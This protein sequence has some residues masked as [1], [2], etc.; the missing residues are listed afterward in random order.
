MNAKL[1]LTIQKTEEKEFELELPYYAKSKSGNYYWKVY[2]ENPTDCIQLDVPSELNNFCGVTKTFTSIIFNNNVE[3][4][5]CS[6]LEF[7]MAY[8]K[9]MNSIREILFVQ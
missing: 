9:V 1:K 6:P 8:E 2:G 3:N 7:D 4:T 5:P